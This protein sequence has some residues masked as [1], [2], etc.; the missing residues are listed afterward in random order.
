M[1]TALFVDFDNVFS[2]L[3]KIS[4]QC[5]ERFARNPSRWLRWLTEDLEQPSPVDGMPGAEGFRRVLVR[6]CYLNPVL[7]S[8]FRRPFH[9]AGFEIVDCPPMTA[10][11]KTSTDIHMVLDTMDALQDSTRFDEFV[12]LSADADFSPLLRRLRRHDRRTVVFAAGAM[13]ESYKASADLVIDI[14]TFIR[15]GLGVAEAEQGEAQ[16]QAA[17]VTAKPIAEESFLRRRIADLVRRKVNGKIEP[18]PLATVAQSILS[19]V[20]GARESNWAGAG[21]FGALMRQMA[22][23]GVVVDFGGDVVYAEAPSNRGGVEVAHAGSS[24][25]LPLSASTQSA[26][27]G[28]ALDKAASDLVK[29]IVSQAHRPVHLSII[30]SQ[31]RSKFSALSPSWSGATTLA[32]FLAR[33]DLSPLR[34]EALDDGSTYVLLD[35]ARHS[36]ASTAVKDATVAAILRAAEFPLMKA[37]DLRLVVQHLMPHLGTDVPFEIATVARSIHDEIAL[38]H[39]KVPV[40]RIAAVMRALIFGGLDTADKPADLDALIAIAMGVLL[41]AW[42]RETQAKV[43][44]DARSRLLAWFAGAESLEGV[45]PG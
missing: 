22:I 38:Q 5:A 14:P 17:A 3:K 39:N 30:G 26:L 37:E 42:S 13:S 27:E 15:E 43:D 33:L 32:T 8:Q 2:G 45:P 35:P 24:P 19:D 1:K 6:R 21:S 44:D 28:D 20:S 34:R 41:A 25:A 12:M 16:P 18:L 23:S 31:L 29:D 9:E 36:V 4:S 11:G 40:G 10:T 7:F